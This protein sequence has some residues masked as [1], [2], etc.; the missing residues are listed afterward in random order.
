MWRQQRSEDSGICQDNKWNQTRAEDR[1]ASGIRLWVIDGE[2]RVSEVERD[3]VV[4][5][6]RKL[7]ERRRGMGVENLDGSDGERKEHRGVSITCKWKT[8][9]LFGLLGCRLHLLDFQFAFS[10][11]L[12]VKK[13]EDIQVE[14]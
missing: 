8:L 11:T 2:N 7:L 4:G 5:A 3:W 6:G 10:L 14:M 1:G 9:W 13:F 12:P